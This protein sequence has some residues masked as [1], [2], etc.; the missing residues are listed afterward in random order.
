M[1]KR[2]QPKIKNTAFI[3]RRGILILYLTAQLVG[4]GGGGGNSGGSISLANPIVTISVS[5]F[6]I[7]QYLSEVGQTNVLADAT[8]TST[9]QIDYWHD[10]YNNVT[11]TFTRV[12]TYAVGTF[13][14]PNAYRAEIAGVTGTLNSISWGSTGNTTWSM[15]N[16]NA[17]ASTLAGSWQSFWTS[18]YNTSATIMATGPASSNLTCTNSTGQTFTQNLT[19]TAVNIKPFIASCIS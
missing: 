13:T 15:T 12:D 2:L 11:Q 1:E 16:A 19:S 5:S 14:L 8:D 3:S 6:P 17:D 9:T 7:S 4:C 10:D 18:V